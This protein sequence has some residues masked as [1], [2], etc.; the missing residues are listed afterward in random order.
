M[1]SCPTSA[2]TSATYPAA[3][4]RGSV[5]SG[6]ARTPRD[7]PARDT[8]V[9]AATR[10]ACPARTN[11]RAAASAARSFPSVIKI[12]MPTHRDATYGPDRASNHGVDATVGVPWWACLRAP[13][14]LRSC[15]GGSHG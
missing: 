8:P 11:D 3:S 10:T 5:A 7:T 6:L 1:S 14:W 2:P 4:V 12:R 9:R 15:K 13:L